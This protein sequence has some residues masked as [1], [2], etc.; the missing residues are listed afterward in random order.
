MHASMAMIVMR[1]QL[2]GLMW[3]LLHSHAA[4]VALAS[5]PVLATSAQRS[6]CPSKCGDVNIP[7]PFGIGDDCAW[8]GFTVSCNDSFSPPK[9]YNGDVEIID[10]SLEKGQMHIY[11]LVA[12]MCYNSTNT[13]ESHFSTGITS[14]DSPFLVAQTSNEFTAI[15]CDTLAWLQGRDD[16]SFKTGCITTCASLDT[17]A[18]DNETCTGLGCCQLPSIPANLSNIEIDLSQVSGNSSWTYSPCSYAFVAKK[19]WYHFRRQ[20]FSHN[21][22]KLFVEDSD[23]HK[24]VR[25]VIDWAIRSNG[26]CPSEKKAPACVSN[27]SYCID[28]TNGEGYLCNCSAGYAGNPYVTGDGGCKN[29]NECELRKV[30]PAKYEKL[31]P[32]YGGSR[33][34][35]TEGD[36]ECKCRFGHRGDGKINDKGCRPIISAS[37]LAT[38][39]TV[40]ACAVLAILVLYVLKEH[41]KRQRNRSFDKNGGNIIKRMMDIKLFTEEQLKKMTKNYQDVLGKGSFGEVYKGTIE[42]KQD[43]AVKRY[44]RQDAKEQYNK[45]HVAEEITNQA[46]IQH[47]NLLRLVGCCLETD[48]PML[49]MEFIPKGSLHNMLHSADRHSYN[50]SL[51]E[52]LCIAIGCAEALAYMHSNDDH[53]SIVH[54]DIKSENILLDDKLEPKVADFGSSKLNSIAKYGKWE[55]KT[56]WNYI[57]P[58]Y[59]KT[60]K[61]C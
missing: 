58:T 29:I 27:N 20:D 3:F 48:V 44:I 40:V 5:L 26:S 52:R 1:L 14:T 12:S 13:T 16:K 23:G 56:D 28:A 21:G 2:L 6:G 17:A 55:V 38:V 31:Y 32:C 37:I 50:F 7:Y 42:D 19:D 30:D 47:A 34:H 53:K 49:V 35:D 41:K 43:V 10:I 8:P 39:A 33:C 57:D 15:G 4:A 22:S 36:Y 46:R 60:T 11:T 25:T 45:E 54:G 9:P 51:L 24:N 18:Q 61:F 59:L